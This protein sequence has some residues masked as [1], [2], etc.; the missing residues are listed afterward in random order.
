L[1]I[2]TLQAIC[3]LIDNS[4]DEGA[5]IIR[6][7][8]E[9]NGKY[10]RI[11]VADDGGGIPA[12]IRRH[13]TEY[14]GLSYAL[15]FGGRYNGGSPGKIGK[16][17]FGLS[18]SASCQSLKT[19]VYTQET[20][21]DDF[22]YTYV[23]IDEM[24]DSRTVRPP[25]TKPDVPATSDWPQNFDDHGTL[26]ILDKCDSPDRKSVNG[27][28]K[29]LIPQLGRIYRRYLRADRDIVVNQTEVDPID[30]LFLMDQAHNT[31]EILSVDDPYRETEVKLESP[32]ED[33][34]SQYPVKI[35]LVKLPVERIRRNENW[36]GDWMESHGLT[37]QNQ[38]FSLMRDRR[39]IASGHSLRLFTKHQEHNYFRG[40]ITFP[41]ELDPYFGIEANKSNFSLKDPAKDKIENEVTDAIS[42]IK[43]EKQRTIE[44]IE[45][46]EMEQ[47]QEDGPSVGEEVAKD[48]DHILKTRKQISS[49]DLA[50]EEQR[51]N[52]QEAEKLKEVES[53]EDLTQEE[54]EAQKQEITAQFERRKELP[55]QVEF[56]HMTD[57]KFYDP[58]FCYGDNV[59]VRINKGHPFFDV[60]EQ[61]TQNDGDRAL[62]EMLIFS[63]AHSEL[64][65]HDNAKM[66][67]FLDQFM[68]EWSATL[69]IYLEN[70]DDLI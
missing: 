60:Y 64:M 17:G 33:D 40:E 51:L 19:E 48:A 54:R 14:D 50:Q 44:R 45:K 29:Y 13:G 34:S 25:S 53:N 31:S 9:E 58:E 62:L 5:N 3:E 28:V 32:S 1:G 41:P 42:Q 70:K 26:V 12:T 27:M 47:H 52:E 55:F 4:L 20:H 23:D 6:I 66:Q 11:C 8:I 38:G 36:S 7:K 10:L 37:Q 49:E 69:K 22:R 65:H 18:S 68:R 15:S 56:D 39:E 63:A 67:E 2:S 21:E 59:R 35:K 24:I 61:A 16:F 57:W 30:P 46:E 43:R